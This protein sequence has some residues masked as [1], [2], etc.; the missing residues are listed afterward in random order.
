MLSH[1][2]PRNPTSPS[3]HTVYFKVTVPF[4][5]N[6]LIFRKWRSGRCVPMISQRNQINTPPGKPV[7]PEKQLHP[8]QRER[9][10]QTA[11]LWQGASFFF[12]FKL[13][14]K[15]RWQ[16]TSPAC[17]GWGFMSSSPAQSPREALLSEGSQ[18]GPDLARKSHHCT[19]TSYARKGRRGET[20]LCL[21]IG[22][23]T[24]DWIYRVLGVC[25]GGLIS[26]QKDSHSPEVC[27]CL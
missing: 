19:I 24:V 26:T 12:L 27:P 11:S 5:R 3:N 8:A 7:L 6:C 21:A 14:N 15:E 25:H 10:Q 22:M 13:K 2:Y 18:K 23:P 4:W 1:K 9:N 20:T 17:K 16:A